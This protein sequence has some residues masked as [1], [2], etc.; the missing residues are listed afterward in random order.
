MELLSKAYGP[1]KRPAPLLRPPSRRR[2]G[3]PLGLQAECLERMPLGA[4]ATANNFLTSLR[5]TGVLR[6]TNCWNPYVMSK[7]TP[8]QPTRPQ[9]D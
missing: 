1:P 2:L 6:S 5:G 7:T 3:Q 9:H 4:Q 8:P